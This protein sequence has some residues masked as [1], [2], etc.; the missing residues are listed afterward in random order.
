MKL[1]KQ[2]VVYRVEEPEKIQELKSQGFKEVKQK[3]KLDLPP[4]E[5]KEPEN[6]KN[7]KDKE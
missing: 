1:K 6:N 7:G 3:S 5:G 2:N 4:K